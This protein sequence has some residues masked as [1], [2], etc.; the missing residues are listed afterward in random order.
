M[1][2]QRLELNFADSRVPTNVMLGDRG[3][4]DSI[5]SSFR[6]IRDN[7]AVMRVLQRLRDLHGDR[8]CFF[9]RH[10]PAR[11]AVGQGASFDEFQHQSPFLD[12][13]YRGDVR[14]I[15][16]CQHLRFAREPRHA[17]GIGGER[18]GQQFDGDV[19]VEL[20]VGGA[21]L[22]P[23]RLNRASRGSCSGRSTVVGSSGDFRNVITFPSGSRAIRK[24]AREVNL[25]GNAYL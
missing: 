6:T 19:A 12:A 15:E 14:V 11:D 22:R 18:R 13:V 2:P 1:E 7:A 21:T 25:T 3:V 23:Y 16:C 4:L 17:I 20:G 10:L 9:Q 8:Q 24:L 5:R